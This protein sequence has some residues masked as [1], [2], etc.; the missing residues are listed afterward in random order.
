M[1]LAFS[2]A[3]TL[4]AG[5]R[6]YFIVAGVIVAAL[7][8]AA[9]GAAVGSWIGKQNGHSTASQLLAILLG[10]PGMIAAVLLPRT[11]RAE[12]RWRIQVKR[13]MEDELKAA[14]QNPPQAVPRD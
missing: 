10:P 1:M 9:A 6:T 8:W 13:A 4:T 14:A 12:A 5:Q 7:A 3:V 11:P 2:G